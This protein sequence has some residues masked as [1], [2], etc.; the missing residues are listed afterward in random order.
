MLEKQINGKLSYLNNAILL[1][2]V[3]TLKAIIM[4]IDLV[5]SI[6]IIRNPV[7][8]K[9]NTATKRLTLEGTLEK[10]GHA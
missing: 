3:P 2:T 9:T 5:T 10:L 8:M 7:I 1:E 4:S 6:R